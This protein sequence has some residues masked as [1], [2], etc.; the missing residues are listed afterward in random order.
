MDHSN[1]SASFGFSKEQQA[2]Q[3]SKYNDKME[4]SVVS[5]INKVV[6]GGSVQGGGPLTLQ[7]SLKSLVSLIC[8]RFY[9]CSLSFACNGQMG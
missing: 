1:D 5:W 3:A 8:G 7:S 4:K 6:G 2:K 9:F